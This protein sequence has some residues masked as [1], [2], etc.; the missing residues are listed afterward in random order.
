[1]MTAAEAF[2][3]LDIR[4]VLAAVGFA[5]G[6]VVVL[7]GLI[8]LHDSEVHGSTWDFIHWNLGSFSNDIFSTFGNPNHLGG[9]LAI[10]L[11]IVLVLGLGTKRWWWR[12]AA[13]VFALALLA[14]LIRT[15]ARGA[16][17]AAIVALAVLAAMLAPEIKRRPTLAAGGALG[18]VAVAAI[19]MLA[20]GKH[21]LAHP[22][23][24]LF[25]R[26]V[27]HRSSSAT[28]SGRRRSISPPIIP[29]PGSG[30]MPSP[31]CTPST[32]APR[33]WLP[34]DPTTSSTARTTSS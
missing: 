12:A 14:E 11:P 4:K 25:H 20:G 15:S 21:F 16:W 6:G 19:A 9:F 28:T 29:S 33:G 22:L 24:T 27:P 31:S 30:R 7:Y 18:V 34:C 5:G 3:A 2:D 10:I 32:R 26:G 1:M 23:S 8:Q 13:G 17:V